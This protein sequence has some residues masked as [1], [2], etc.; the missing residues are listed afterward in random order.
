MILALVTAAILLTASSG[1]LALPFR[2]T[3]ARAQRVACAA[4]CA[5]AVLGVTGAVLA[6]RAPAPPALALPWAA[7][8]GTFALRLDGLSALFLLPVLVVP[9][10]GS[11]YGLA[12]FPQARL[13][14][15]AVRLQIFYGLVTG[16]MALV[17]AAANAILFL[18][19]W[20]VM[21]LCGF[22]LV[23]T[24]HEVPETQRAAFVYLASAH[25]GNLALFAAFA[26]L[27]KLAGTLDF[28][29]MGGLAAHGGLATAVF[30]LALGGFGLKAGLLPLHF[31]LPGA[32]AAAPSHV[33]AL[34]SG[35]LLKTGIYGIL[36]VT[37]FFDGPPV[38]WGTLVLLGGAVSAVLG[39]AF[40]LAQHDVKRL[41]AYHSVE[42]IGI[43]A[44]GIGLALLGRALG[45]PALV[46][47]GFAAAVLHVVN[48]ATFKALLFL[49]AGAVIHATG[50]REIDH[51]GGLARAMPRTAALFLVGAAAIS[52]LPPLN[53]FASEWLVYVASV[54]T[55]LHGG[56]VPQPHFAVLGA[57]VL[58]FVGGL[59]AACFAKVFGAVFLGHA[60]SPHAGGAHEAPA[61]MLVPMAV[62]AGVCVVIGVA[63]A[64]L[65][66]ALAKAAAQWSGVAP[67]ALAGPAAEA[68]ASAMRV[69]AVA[70]ALVGA[71]LLLALLRRARLRA[72][73]PEAETWGCGY[74]RPT[75]RMQYTGS[76]FA[77][78]LV[79]RFGWV[80][81]PRARVEPPRGVF[82]RR[83]SFSSSVPDTVLD[84]AITPATSWIGRLAARARSPLLGSVQVQAL[85]LVTGVIV[86]LGWLALAGGAP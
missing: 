48:H 74:A 79:L 14:G 10:L 73:Q 71:V 36:R 41:L 63:P 3:P 13:G 86:L 43:I 42:N 50:T 47:L 23:L 54:R 17:V 12:Y 52:G 28:A 84:V 15:K 2:R 56:P 19:A 9:A 33:S 62:L 35:V 18:A 34:M 38:A 72:P 80:F 7:P 8:G 44:M 26:L 83:A 39:V 25:A 45:D 65:L 46:F 82:P 77:E 32:H 81:F 60:R 24:D 27:G 1:A 37:G 55:A 58:A 22:F 76:S 20:E 16:A 11:I 21:A 31:W 61:P 66:P 75:A 69:S 51:L 29:G 4:M 57:P 85:L 53:G 49:G 40:A 30:V 59:A 78:M 68:G 64:A 67:A 6:L 5:G 70:A